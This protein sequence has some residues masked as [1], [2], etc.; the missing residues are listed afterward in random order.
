M[1]SA[2]RSKGRQIPAFELASVVA[3]WQGY[4]DVSQVITTE[5]ISPLQVTGE[6]GR[7]GC[8]LVGVAFDARH[9]T[10]YHTRGLTTEDLVHE[11]LHVAHPLWSEARVV[12]ETKRLWRPGLRTPASLPPMEVTK[13]A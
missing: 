4:F 13:A 2:I 5:R 6:G 3:A 12:L 1:C 11:L 7:P 10:I 9:A 8:A